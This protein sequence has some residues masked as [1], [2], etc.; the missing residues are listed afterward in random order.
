MSELDRVH[1][2]SLFLPEN[3]LL[4]SGIEGLRSACLGVALLDIEALV[5]PNTPLFTPREAGRAS[6][7]GPRRL[8]NFT[9]ARVALKI[10]SRQLGLVKTNRPDWTIETLGPD[11]VKPCLA[12]S[13][14]YCSV[15]HS[16]RFVVAVA[17]R[18]PIGV[19]I[20]A[21]SSKTLRT[22]HLFL[23]P[24]ERELLSFSDLGPER[25][26]TRAWTIKEAA[27]KALGLQLV[28]TFHEVEIFRAG[29]NEGAV[30]YRGKTFPV[31]HAE[32]K[33]QVITLI[34]ADAL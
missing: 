6:Q 11:A 15:S 3:N 8:K 23:G 2:S 16:A 20:E 22:R 5:A 18:Y 28:E 10:L 26:F 13:G 21:I 7:M 12:E 29:E 25:A 14:I 17:H 30:K 27:A 4:W 24:E 31:R 19:D 1:I 9:A 34:T 33:G 32:G